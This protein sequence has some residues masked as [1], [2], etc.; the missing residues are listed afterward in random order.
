MAVVV[1]LAGLVFQLRR[2]PNAGTPSGAKRPQAPCFSARQRVRCGTPQMSAPSPLPLESLDARARKL[3]AAVRDDPEGRYRLRAEFY[4]RYGGE[5]PG[6]FGYGNSEM[7]FLRW[8]I[9]RATLNPPGHQRPGSPWWRAVNEEFIYT[10][11]LAGLIY[12]SGGEPGEIPRPVR[13]WLDY[14]RQPGSKAWYRAHNASIVWAYIQHTALARDESAAE[15]AFVNVVLYRV[16]YAESL[17]EG[18]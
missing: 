14:L 11:E 1:L 13:C 18:A 17:E 9:E 10:A 16:L 6:E 5:A 2:A 7:A 8:E 3:V 12:D 15:R 4:R